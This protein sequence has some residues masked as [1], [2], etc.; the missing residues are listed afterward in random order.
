MSDEPEAYPGLYEADVVDN[1]DPL[2][3]RRLKVRIHVVHGAAQEV[4]DTA[5]PWA[6]PCFPSAGKTHGDDY[7]FE[8]GDGVWIMF[9]HGNP[10]FP[11]WMGGWYGTGEGPTPE[12]TQSGASG[13]APTGSYRKTPK[14]WYFG[15][16]EK[17]KLYKIKSPL[18]FQFSI[19]EVKK[20]ITA[21]TP[22]GFQIVIDET[23]KKI[24]LKGL[25]VPYPLAGVVTKMHKCAYTG[26]PHPEGSLE[27]EASG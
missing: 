25:G 22:T 4:P 7:T 27:V 21:E 9:R 13:A 5:L 16:D 8:K 18:G 10:E 2:G 19:D 14:G 12:M 17:K 20:A 6:L 11:V 3:R 1:K 24:Q 15:V 26:A 23:S